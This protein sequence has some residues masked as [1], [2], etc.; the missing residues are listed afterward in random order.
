MKNVM[1]TL[2]SHD[3]EPRCLLSR[4]FYLSILAVFLGSCGCSRTVVGG[5]A[6]SPDNKYRVYGRVYGALGRRLYENTAKTVRIT[7]VQ[8]GAT[9]SQLFRKEFHVKGTHV[10]WEATWE[11]AN[12]VKLSVYATDIGVGLEATKT[13]S[14]RLRFDVKAGKF[15]EVATK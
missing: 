12:D 11:T 3:K 6:D 1:L 9:E 5:Y 4:M 13:T 10:S 2:S 8:N 7:I 14:V 15:L